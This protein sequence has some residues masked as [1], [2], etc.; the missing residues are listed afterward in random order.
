MKSVAL[1]LIDSSFLKTTFFSLDFVQ[2]PTL[3]EPVQSTSSSVTMEWRY[4][5]DDPAHSAF[6]TGYL[7]T[8]QEVGTDTL[9]GHHPASERRRKPTTV[10]D[11]S[12]Y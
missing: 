2:S 8:V 5:E 12:L 7:V 11:L 3:V 1:I 6:V 9:P 4:S 10:P